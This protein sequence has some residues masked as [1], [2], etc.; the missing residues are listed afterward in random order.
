[1]RKFFFWLTLLAIVFFYLMLSFFGA[2][3]IGLTPTRNETS[4]L[5]A[6]VEILRSL[7]EAV[8]IV[9]AGVWAYEL[10]IKNRY[11]HPYPK[12]QHRIEHH[13]LSDSEH[14]TVNPDLVYL[15]VFVTVTNEGKTKLDL[16]SGEIHV[17][18]VKPVSPKLRPLI[19]WEANAQK[20][21]EGDV[22]G[23][24]NLN[25]RTVDWGELGYRKWSSEHLEKKPKN[26]LVLEPGQ[27]REIHF[28][29]LLPRGLQL[30][31][32][33]SFF[34]YENSYWELSTL[35]PLTGTQTN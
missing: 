23:L 22:P 8:A 31:Q 24:F 18:R 7:T 33:L 34:E 6:S 27:V 17:R 5:Q 2:S 1:M 29:F 3:F 25:R 20:L 9:I 32:V 14:P 28:D 16:I 11:D 21:R 30:V 26:Y 15:S 10:Y 12:I 13:Y 4:D 19:D 35:Y